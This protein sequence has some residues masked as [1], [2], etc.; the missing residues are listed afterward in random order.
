MSS[1]PGNGGNPLTITLANSKYPNEMQHNSALN[2][3]LHCLLRLKHH[4]GIEIHNDLENSTCDPL[5]CTIGSL[6]FIVSV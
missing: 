6:I 4:S 1:N 5:K 3:V 2:Q